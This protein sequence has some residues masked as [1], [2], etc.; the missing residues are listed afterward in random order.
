MS[1]TDWERVYALQDGDI[2]LSDIPEVTR[3]AFAKAIVRRGFGQIPPKEKITLRLDVDVLTWFR[4]QADEPETH[5]DAVL[6]AY[7][8]EASEQA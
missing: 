1:Q 3:E 6:R 7:M 4:E 2:D 5:I 8:K